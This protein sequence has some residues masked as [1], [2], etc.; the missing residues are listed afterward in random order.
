MLVSCGDCGYPGDLPRVEGTYLVEVVIRLAILAV[1]LSD[2]A[3]ERLD[4]LFGAPPT[5]EAGQTF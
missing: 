3:I 1:E 4:G 2:S 5:V